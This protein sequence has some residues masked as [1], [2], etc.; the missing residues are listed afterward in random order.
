MYAA[1]LSKQIQQ[2]KAK[3]KATVITQYQGVSTQ[4]CRTETRDRDYLTNI[5]PNI[6]V[7]ET[8]YAITNLKQ[9]WHRAA[10]A[11]PHLGSA[12]G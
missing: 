10:S 6:P 2:A 7:I 3:P 12:V 11:A 5:Q 9:V 4:N 8:E 1:Q